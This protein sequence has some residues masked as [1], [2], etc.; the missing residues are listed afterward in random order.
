MT[1]RI[2]D[3]DW[4]NATQLVECGGSFHVVCGKSAGCRGGGGLYK[5]KMADDVHAHH[6]VGDTDWSDATQMVAA[7]GS[8]LVVTG[9]VACCRGNGHLYRVLC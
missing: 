3:C 1:Q 9:R 7:G 4:K 6:R 2:G 8:L 5:V